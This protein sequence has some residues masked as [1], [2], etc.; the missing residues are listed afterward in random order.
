MLHGCVSPGVVIE[1]KSVCST[2]SHTRAC[3]L[4]VLHKSVYPT[5]VARP[6]TRPS[7]KGVCGNFKGHTS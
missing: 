3:D 4:A 1:T 2:R 7:N 6:S 5:V